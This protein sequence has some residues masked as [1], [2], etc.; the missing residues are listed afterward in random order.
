M[1]SNLMQYLANR[2]TMPKGLHPL[3][4]ARWCLFIDNICN[5]EVKFSQISHDSHHIRNNEYVEIRQKQWYLGSGTIFLRLVTF[6]RQFFLER[7]EKE[8]FKQYLAK[9]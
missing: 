5:K 6:R 3:I 2:V 8:R 7:D 9:C 1:A 4:E